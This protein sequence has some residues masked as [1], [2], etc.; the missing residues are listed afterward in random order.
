MMSKYIPVEGHQDLLRDTT[1]GALININKTEMERAK[2]IKM[3]KQQQIDTQE[4]MNNRLDKLESRIDY[5]LST[6][7][8]LNEKI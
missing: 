8:S 5:I 2:S 4:E 6:L 7:T 1:T 3:L